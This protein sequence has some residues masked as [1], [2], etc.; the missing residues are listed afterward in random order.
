MPG[1]RPDDYWFRKSLPK[2]VGAGMGFRGKVCCFVTS[3]RSARIRFDAWVEPRTF[4]RRPL[5]SASG[6]RSVPRSGPHED[7]LSVLVLRRFRRRRT[8]LVQRQSLDLVIQAHGACRRR[9]A[10]SLVRGWSADDNSRP[11]HAPAS[12]GRAGSWSHQLVDPSPSRVGS[13][14][15]YGCEGLGSRHWS[16][17][18]SAAKASLFG[19]LP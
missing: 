14:Q 11:A 8:R 4:R 6:Q 15:S 18:P 9:P 3:R 5:H 12:I 16:R 10:L 19:K 13:R 1:M 2:S 17:A 7:T